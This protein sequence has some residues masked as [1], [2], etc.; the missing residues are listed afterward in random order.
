[1]AGMGNNVRVALV[2]IF[3]TVSAVR[4][5]A[6]DGEIAGRIADTQAAGLPSVRVTAASGDERRE[7]LTDAAGHFV[8]QSLRLGTYRVTVELPGF[9][10][11]SGTIT[12][13]PASPRAHIE[14]SLRVGCI[15]EDLRVT[16]EVREAAPVVDAIVH[17]RVKS[18]SGP[19]LWSLRPDCSGT[20][21]HD[22]NVEVLGAVPGR[23]GTDDRR[24]TLQ[25]LGTPQDVRLE[26]TREYLALLYRTPWLTHFRA[27]PELVF[28][29]VDGRV[30]SPEAGALNGLRVDEAL[31]M[32]RK[33]SRER[34]RRPLRSNP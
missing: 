28:P 10:E 19:V 12:L 27:W 5:T 7:V 31:K 17:V 34:P 18:D 22:Y 16:L 2:V 29:I 8:L 14:W 11:Q 15:N 13:S 20:M 33:W 24:T 26:V 6:T 32:L 1:M 25:V 30:T 3:G 4:Q 21:M 9:I 23:S